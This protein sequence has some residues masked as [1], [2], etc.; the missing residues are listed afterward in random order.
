MFSRCYRKTC[1]RCVDQHIKHPVPDQSEEKLG[2]PLRY[3]NGALWYTLEDDSKNE[4][5]YKTFLQ[6]EEDIRKSKEK[7]LPD[8]DLIEG[9]HPRCQV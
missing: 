6:L 5:H 1:Q 3:N 9:P 4:G 8:T 2:L 7:L